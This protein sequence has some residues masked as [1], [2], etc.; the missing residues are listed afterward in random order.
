MENLDCHNSAAWIKTEDLKTELSSTNGKFSMETLVEEIRIVVHEKMRLFIRTSQF[1]LKFL[2]HSAC[3]D[4]DR[5]IREI[6]FPTESS[7]TNVKFSR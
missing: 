6:G 3:C 2:K 5:R 4:Y 7:S 1:Y